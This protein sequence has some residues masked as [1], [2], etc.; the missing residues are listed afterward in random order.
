M[1]ISFSPK[2]RK[3]IFGLPDIH[4]AEALLSLPVCL[5]VA[6]AASK[7]NDQAAP[8]VTNVACRSEYWITVSK[9]CKYLIYLF[10]SV[11]IAAI[12]A[13]PPGEY[14]AVISG[15]WRHSMRKP[16]KSVVAPVVVGV[17]FAIPAFAQGK[18]GKPGVDHTAPQAAPIQLGTSGGNATNIAN[19]YCSSGTLGALLQDSSVPTPRY[20]ILS[21]AH[22]LAHDIASSTGDPDTADIGNDVTQPGL[23]DTGCG[24]YPDLWVADLAS[25]SSLRSADPFS[26]VDAAVAEAVPG[27]VSA[28]GAILEIGPI[29]SIPNA[30]APGQGVKKSG[31]TTGLTKSQVDSINATVTVQYDDEPHGK[32]FTR[33]FTGQVLVRNRGSKFLNAGDSGSL[34]VANV[35]A[36]ARPIGL[37]FAG[38]SLIAVAN[39]VQDVLAYLNDSSTIVNNATKPLSFVGSA[40]GSAQID[41][42]LATAIAAQKANAAALERVPGSVG[43]AVGIENGR[44]FIKVLVD[45]VTLEALR[46]VPDQVDGVRVAL[47]AVGRVVAF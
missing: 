28:D 42:G 39:P 45:R 11:W 41:S 25:L 9:V 17:A 23:V 22:V 8:Q 35:A 37:L 14:S 34:M 19:G 15:P 13:S 2:R 7:L 44:A 24:F 16:W 1:G 10:R 36:N 33:T 43:H 46:S 32:A 29:S 4:N 47:E 38:S 31:R 27:M 5:A 18:G 40:V 3:G 12:I 26:N 20:Y 21:N 30:A 6:R